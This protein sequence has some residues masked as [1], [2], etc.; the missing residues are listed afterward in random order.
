M[1]RTILIIFFIFT[2]CI[3]Y[4]QHE[5]VGTADL[6]IGKVSIIRG[7]QTLKPKRNHE[8]L[9]SDVLETGP[10]A[11][12][13]IKLVDGNKINLTGSREQKVSDIISSAFSRRSSNA[14]DRFMNLVSRLAKDDDSHTVMLA[15][16]GVRGLPDESA[17]LD[18]ISRIEQILLTTSD[19]GDQL[20]LLMIRVD[21]YL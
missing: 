15:T 16:M 6:I 21:L 19:P 8:I 17:I 7:D 20:D 12:I 1:Q 5:V 11:R 3:L 9:Y 2:F 4:A 18:S 10:G 14:L 13:M